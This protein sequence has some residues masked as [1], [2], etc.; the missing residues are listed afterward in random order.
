MRI[1]QNRHDSS[2][3]LLILSPRA[4]IVPSKITIILTPGAQSDWF[5]RDFSR[6]YNKENDR[7][8]HY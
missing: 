2:G 7:R 8:L 1:G 4:L 5:P 6:S 3:E